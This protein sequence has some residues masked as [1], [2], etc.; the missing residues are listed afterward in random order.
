MGFIVLRADGRRFACIEVARDSTAPD[1][2]DPD[3]PMARSMTGQVA[4]IPGALVTQGTRLGSLFDS[5]VRDACRD[6][7]IEEISI[8]C[9]ISESY[10]VYAEARIGRPGI[11]IV[12]AAGDVFDADQTPLFDLLTDE[13]RHLL[14]R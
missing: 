6:G 13:Q 9:G 2:T 3:F 4:E 7:A 8:G 1:V 10:R 11:M 12:D 14:A 5:H